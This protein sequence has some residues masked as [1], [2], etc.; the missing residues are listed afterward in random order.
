MMFFPLEI[1]DDL[2][3]ARAFDSVDFTFFKKQEEE[4]NRE[5]G[6]LDEQQDVVDEKL[7]NGRL[8]L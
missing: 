5:M 1:F 6:E 8:H 2:W 7:W 3:F 4:I